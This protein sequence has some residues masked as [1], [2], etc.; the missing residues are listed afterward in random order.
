MTAA[1][2]APV[3]TAALLDRHC[4]RA[5]ALRNAALRAA[6]ARVLLYAQSMFGRAGLRAAACGR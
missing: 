6:I 4:R 2:A 5:H 1:G 3:V